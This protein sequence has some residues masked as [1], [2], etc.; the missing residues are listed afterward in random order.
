[1]H[2]I[3]IEAK[4]AKPY[5]IASNHL[6]KQQQIITTQSKDIEIIKQI[7]N[8]NHSSYITVVS[9]QQ[10]KIINNNIRIS[11]FTTIS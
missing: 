11:T 4:R 2:F 9:A 6:E 5:L 7:Y 8:S 10:L 1:M 3:P